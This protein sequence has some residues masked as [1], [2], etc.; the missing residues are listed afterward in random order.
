MQY[1]YGKIQDP[2]IKCMIDLGGFLDEK[3]I[4]ETVIEL[5]NSIPLLKCRFDIK[6]HRWQKENF[7]IDDYFEIVED[8]NSDAE[9]RGHFMMTFINIDKEAPLKIFLIR[10]GSYDSLC[11]IISHMICDGAGFKQLI[12]LLSDIYSG[13][14]IE[15]PQIIKN[16][17]FSQVTADFRF[18]KKLKIFSLKFKPIIQTPEMF[19][20]LSGKNETAYIV[21][22]EIKEEDFLVIINF[23]KIYGVTVNDMILAAYARAL[24]KT[25]N[26]RKIVL[27]CFVDLRK[28][29]KSGR[30][31]GICNLTSQYLCEI[32]F[33]RKDDF[34]KTLGIISDEMRK[35]KNSDNCL[36]GPMLLN[37]VF[38]I[39]PFS[40]IRKNFLKIS[41]IPVT[42]YTN[43]GILDK[44]KLKFDDN[45]IKSAYFGTS[46]RK[47]PYFQI[48]VSTYSEVLYLTSSFYGIADDKIKVLKLMEDLKNELIIGA[49]NNTKAI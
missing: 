39:L 11:I 23:A 26:I 7:S 12:Y 35:N 13:R 40:F 10:S 46:V 24:C 31:C 14:K 43:I 45:E 17:K 37:A 41:P 9:L 16:R 4:K 47:Q 42:C 19:F 33:D 1:F 28:Y 3:K 20:P 36:K 25:L 21:K 2:L 32:T 18:L 15:N 44:E 22:T 5:I 6:K 49:A 30:M 34:Q 38:K 29:I 48:S 27:P 8:K